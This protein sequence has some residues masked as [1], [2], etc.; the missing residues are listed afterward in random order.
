MTCNLRHPMGLRH[1]VQ[2]TLNNFYCI[3]YSANLVCIE[4]KS[5]KSAR[6]IYFIMYRVN[7]L[8]KTTKQ[9][10][11]KNCYC[12]KCTLQIVNSFE[13]L[14]QEAF[15]CGSLSAKEPLI[16]GLFCGKRPIKIRHPRC[17]RQW[18]VAKTPFDLKVQIERMC[19]RLSSFAWV[20]TAWYKRDGFNENVWYKL[21]F[22]SQPSC[23][24]TNI[25][26][27]ASA[28]MN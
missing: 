3:M 16:I 11:F 5:Q 1:P 9:L 20:P 6:S 10:T 23:T 2:L 8:F 15:S 7:S 24:G 28:P 25:P 12:I 27:Y 13:I 26:E 4:W 21:R 22:F 14:C 19:R 18:H 17:L